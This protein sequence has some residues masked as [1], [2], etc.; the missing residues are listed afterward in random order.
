MGGRALQKSRE[1][2]H[3]DRAHDRSGIPDD[4][5]LHWQRRELEAGWRYPHYE[6]FYDESAGRERTVFSE[7]AS[8]ERYAG[9]PPTRDKGGRSSG[10]FWAICGPESGKGP[11]GYRRSDTRLLEDVCERLT[12]HGQLNASGI[13][14]SCEK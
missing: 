2:H 7:D 6:G 5:D 9:K 10:E 13:K 14:V 8:A 11:K 1:V 12:K 3:S 4:E